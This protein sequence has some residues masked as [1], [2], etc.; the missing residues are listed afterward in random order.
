[1]PKSALHPRTVALMPKILHYACTMTLRPVESTPGF[2]NMICQAGI[3]SS[4]E[5]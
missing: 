3:R 1:M 5:Y 4:L 2:I